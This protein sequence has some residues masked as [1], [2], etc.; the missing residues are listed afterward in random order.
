M[1]I[2]KKTPGGKRKLGIPVLFLTIYRA[3]RHPARRA[4]EMAHGAQIA[5]KA[6]KND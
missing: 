6:V 1:Q 4:C 5:N 3:R 2:V